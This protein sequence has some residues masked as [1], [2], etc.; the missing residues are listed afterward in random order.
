MPAFL[1]ELG[2]WCRD[3]SMPSH[4][5]E[6]D[7]LVVT[8]HPDA[9][10]RLSHS[11]GRLWFQQRVDVPAATTDQAA[12]RAC[13]L[14]NLARRGVLNARWR[15]GFVEI[16]GSLRQH[17]CSRQSVLWLLEEA[18]LLADLISRQLRPTAEPD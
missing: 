11:V 17:D 7:V 14:A 13:Q 3:A 10:V 18:A 15:V 16:T 2:G 1:D 8:P 12:I 9:E 5:T 6:D 4:R